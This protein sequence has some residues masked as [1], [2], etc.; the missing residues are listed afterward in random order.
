MAGLGWTY[1]ELLQWL[2]AIDFSHSPNPMIKQLLITYSGS[3]IFG[4]GGHSVVIS[5]SPHI[6]AKVSLQQGDERLR[7]EQ[8]ILEQLDQLGCTYVIQPFFFGVDIS[9]L[10]L[11]GHGTLHDRMR[12][13]KPR[14]ILQW[15]LQLSS[16][17]A[18]LE[19]LGYAHG[20]INPRNI[21]LDVFDQV[22]LIYF[23]HSLRAGDG[24]DVGYEPYVRQYRHETL[25]DYGT[26]GPVTEQLALGAVFWYMTRGSELYSELDGPDRVDRLLDGHFP[27]TDL[28]DPV[29]TI[30]G[31][32][33]Q[34][35]YPQVDDLVQDIKDLGVH[36]P[37]E[38]TVS[39]RQRSK[40]T[41]LCEHHYRRLMLKKWE[42]IVCNED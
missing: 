9:F 29:D 35:S 19:S 28:Q 31:K 34:G 3:Y 23:D 22:K 21:L 16:A 18:C 11:L 10:E 14:P 39:F 27:L 42:G 38:Q 1:D 20:D 26:A 25:G 24:L 12:N 40:R 33:F 6:V 13:E 15:M 41:R 7:N 17:A 2:H 36:M 37:K 32:C 4:I 30:I 5:V 8:S